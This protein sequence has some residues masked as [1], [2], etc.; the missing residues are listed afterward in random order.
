MRVA[1]WFVVIGVNL[2]IAVLASIVVRWAFASPHEALMDYAILLLSSSAHFFYLR[3]E[4]L[5]F[6]LGAAVVSAALN[7]CA[8]F[9][10]AFAL[11]GQSP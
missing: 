6:K 7:A 3:H 4:T 1:K 2:V 5:R 11:F 9:L 10:V 8:I